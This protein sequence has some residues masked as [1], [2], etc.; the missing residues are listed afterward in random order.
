MTEFEIDGQSYRA[1]KLSAFQQL[2]VSRKLAGILPKVVPALVAATGGGQDMAA[3]LAS[4]EPAAEA[5][6][7]MPEADVDYVYH[8]A[9]SA[10]SRKQGN[11]WCPVW[12]VNAKALQFEDIELETMSR[13]VFQ[14]LKDSLGPFM[15]GLLAQAP[16]AS[17]QAL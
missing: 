6:A 4:F 3:L 5:L 17:P 1:Q 10:V 8:T 11:A 9:L 14:V 13:I 12:N 7:A 2:H 15:Q 16:A